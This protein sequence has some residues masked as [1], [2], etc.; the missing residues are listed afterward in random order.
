MQVGNE[1]GI[2]FRKIDVGFIQLHLCSLSAV[3]HEELPSDFHDLRGGVMPRIW[4]CAATAQNMYS[5]LFQSLFLPLKNVDS[6]FV[7]KTERIV[8]QAQDVKSV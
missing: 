3:N 5:E 7:F 1:N 8:S 6:L 2:E 4:R